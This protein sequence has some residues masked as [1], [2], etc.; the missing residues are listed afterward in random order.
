M[1]RSAYSQC[2]HSV[3]YQDVFGE[4]VGSNSGLIA[5]AELSIDLRGQEDG[6]TVLVLA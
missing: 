3:I 1:L 4:E 5:G 2:Y 6:G